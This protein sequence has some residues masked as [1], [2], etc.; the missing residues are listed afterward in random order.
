MVEDEV[1]ALGSR[2][3]VGSRIL[4]LGFR[5]RMRHKDTDI[6]KERHTDT[7]TQTDAPSH[8]NI[9]TPVLQHILAR[10]ALKMG[11][12]SHAGALVDLFEG[13]MKQFYLNEV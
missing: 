11:P 8:A 5:D 2:L 4:G 1:Y 6:N 3:A 13:L 12:G 10:K 7:Q 9:N